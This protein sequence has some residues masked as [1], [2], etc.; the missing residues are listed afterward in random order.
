VAPRFLPLLRVEDLVGRGQFA[1]VFA[2]PGAEGE[3]CK[4]YRA[5][6]T[7]RWKRFAP[8]ILQDELLAYNQAQTTPQLSRYVARCFGAAIVGVVEGKQGEDRSGDYLLDV[9]LLL[10]RIEGPEEKAMGLPR[11]R[12]SYVYEVAERLHDVGVDVGDASVFNFAD[13]ATMK[14][15]DITMHNGGDLIA[16]YVMGR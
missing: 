6:K 9:G 10:E 1:D 12:Y 8:Q 11:R 2:V 7:D 14:F 5:D 15:V 3:V 16:E 4:L 13:A